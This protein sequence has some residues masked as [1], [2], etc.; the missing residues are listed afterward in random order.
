MADPIVSAGKDIWG[1][2]SGDKPTDTLGHIVS[3]A[4]T[5][6]PF[7]SFGN[8]G[9]DALKAEAEAKANPPDVIH[10]SDALPTTS[11][12]LDPEQFIPN[13]ADPDY[14]KYLDAFGDPQ[15]QEAD[16]SGDM[17]DA[18][19]QTLK[20]EANN[21]N[22]LA[23]KILK[24]YKPEWEPTAT[25]DEQSFVKPFVS[26]LQDLPG[27]YKSLEAQQAALT[28][29]LAQSTTD[30]DAIAKQY[31]GVTPIG[32]DATTQALANSYL[33]T[34]Q[35]A[36]SQSAPVMTAALKD[37]GKAAEESLK[38]FPYTSMLSD[39]LNRYAYN[40]ESPSYLTTPQVTS[41]LPSDLLD[42]MKAAG[43]S[44]SATGSIE[45]QLKDF[46]ANVTADG[47]GGGVI[48]PGTVPTA[49]A[50]SGAS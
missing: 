36:I 38:T 12:G 48:Q 22:D 47:T 28:P 17:S 7:D 39:L 41:G 9:T 14:K 20:E 1:N 33:N 34:A 6:W 35:S 42:L 43:I 44:S 5:Q 11:S 31:G 15:E 27:E 19:W 24:A 18:Q 49:P 46:G 2:L 16:P 40:L 30:V 26:A 50:V 13:K 29:S 8:G 10:G 37:M 3:W 45:Q 25:Q 21:G 4:K 32:P 23:G